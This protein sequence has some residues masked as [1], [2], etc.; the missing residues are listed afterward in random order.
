V[1]R[2]AADCS[3]PPFRV[4]LPRGLNNCRHREFQGQFSLDMISFRSGNDSKPR[5]SAGSRGVFSHQVAVLIEHSDRAVGLGTMQAKRVVMLVVRRSHSVN[6]DVRSKSCV[7]RLPHTCHTKCGLRSRRPRCHGAPQKCSP[8]GCP[9]RCRQQR[10]IATP[11]QN[12][13]FAC[14]GPLV[15]LLLVRPGSRPKHR[16]RNCRLGRMGSALAWAGWAAPYRRIHFFFSS[17]KTRKN[18]CP[19]AH[20]LYVVEC[21]GLT[22]GRTSLAAPAHS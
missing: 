2:F 4:R 13:A 1:P 9:E 16:V 21:T 5:D 17:D 7:A 22:M 6:Y 20:F 10:G 12:H 15:P 3:A 8:V 18:A 14:A 19:P 11:V